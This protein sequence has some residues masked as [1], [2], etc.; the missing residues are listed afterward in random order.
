MKTQ[1]ITTKQL[2]AYRRVAWMASA[3]TSK[4]YFT[5]D[6]DDAFQQALTEV[7]AA[8]GTITPPDDAKVIVREYAEANMERKRS[9]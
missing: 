4:G 1:S 7:I 9:M 3:F 6:E 8:G 2:E 5:M